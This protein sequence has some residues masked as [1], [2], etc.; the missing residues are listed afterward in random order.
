MDLEPI[1][2]EAEG[3]RWRAFLDSI[4]LSYSQIFFSR[5]RRVGALLCAAT[6]VH[7]KLFLGGLA[8]VTAA[9]SVAL[10]KAE[11]SGSSSSGGGV[12]K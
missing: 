4:L 9:T 11:V 5:D 2:Q 8:A 7:P 10:G 1:R 12:S 3:E 6:A